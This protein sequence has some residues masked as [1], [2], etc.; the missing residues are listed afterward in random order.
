MENSSV[1][2]HK[3]LISCGHL[4]RT[5]S[6][7]QRDRADTKT[8]MLRAPT[9]L[10]G[11]KPSIQDQMVA[12]QQKIQLQKYDHR[13]YQE[14]AIPIIKKNQDTIESLQQE[15]KKLKQELAQERRRQADREAKGGSAIVQLKECKLH[16]NIKRLNALCHQV[17]VHIRR[18]E[19]LESLVM[20]IAT[21]KQNNNT[22]QEEQI[23]PLL[24]NKLEETRLKLQDVE[25]INSVY[26]EITIHLQDEIPT[27]QPQIQQLE[28]EILLFGN[29]LKDL[30]TMNQNAAI[31]RD[32]VWAEHQQLKKEYRCKRSNREQ[33]LRDLT[34]QLNERRQY[35]KEQAKAA[36]FIR[37]E[38]PIEAYKVSPAKEEEEEE[39]ICTYEEALEKI[40]EAT[41]AF[42][43]CEV[44]QRFIKQEEAHKYLAKEKSKIETTLSELKEKQQRMDDALQELKYSSQA[45]LQTV[46]SKNQKTLQELRVQLQVE[47]KELDNFKMEAEKISKVLN[48]AT[49][50]VKRLAT[51]LQYIKVPGIHFP[52]KDF[53]LD[54]NVL[55]LLAIVSQKLQNLQKQCEG[56]DTEEIFKQM[57]DEEFVDTIERNLPAS[58]LRIS[59][60][61]PSKQDTYD[62]EDSEEER[63][64]MT[65]ESIKM[66][67]E[68]IT[69]T[70]RKANLWCEKWVK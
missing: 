35:E 49:S 9:T 51:R 64:V 16:D 59:L 28:T 57:K 66:F 34:H 23:Q 17:Q 68:K 42:N 45:N 38:V 60:L 20:Q 24:E 55:D 4:G 58:N 27:F 30:K 21:A 46:L 70:K 18:L 5:V 10:P 53:S 33:I 15:N 39:I 69:M 19:E 65:R 67:S 43:K 41:G 12:L 48:K 37:D 50:E 3:K 26:R 40:K 56:Q 31:S 36:V 32:A 7:S 2:T 22:N 47:S 13:A 61:S 14:S 8:V 54:L 29:E 11:I 6:G 63:N 25:Y 62:D 1:T 44:L 52:E